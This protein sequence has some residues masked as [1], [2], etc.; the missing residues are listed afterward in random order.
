[1]TSIQISASTTKE[2]IE[3]A[4]DVEP[5]P[6]IILDPSPQAAD[7]TRLIGEMRTSALLTKFLQFLASEP[8]TDETAWRAI[9]RPTVDAEV[10]MA[11]L[12]NPHVPPSEISLLLRHPS[13]RVRGHA[14]LAELS[15]RIPRLNT[16]ELDALL[17]EHAGDGGVSLGV[18]HLI[19]RSP[20]SPTR[21]L[22]RL[23]HDEADFIAHCARLRL[24]ETDDT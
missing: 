22:E 16:A 23:A 20:S 10:A 19:A 24:E 8:V 14:V 7:I 13:P 15:L 1:M 4:I 17:D 2:Q 18:R 11:A 3:N 9:L 6:S 21:I 12:G 5:S